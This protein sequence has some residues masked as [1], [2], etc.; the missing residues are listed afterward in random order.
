M[1]EELTHIDILRDY[2]TRSSTNAGD[3]LASIGTNILIDAMLEFQ[4]E[5][6]KRLDR[7]IE[8]L[9]K[10]GEGKWTSLQE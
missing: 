7:I 2:A 6:I 4:I 3:R 9:E 8:L 1:S 10:V 5:Q